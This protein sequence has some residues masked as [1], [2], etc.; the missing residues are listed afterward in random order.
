M[1]K[2]DEALRA[3]KKLELLAKAQTKDAKAQTKDAKAE[4]KD[5]K[6][7]TKDAELTGLSFDSRRRLLD[8][9]ITAQKQLLGELT[10]RDQDIKVS[11]PTLR[12]VP[13][14]LFNPF[15]T[16]MGM[17]AVQMDMDFMDNSAADADP[18]DGVIFY[19]WDPVDPTR[20]VDLDPTD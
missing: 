15:V 8:S 4:T 3:K 10:V 13:R 5:A 18:T 2:E 12:R 17:M 1:T 19:D 16:S 7:E 11:R 14:S 6:A 20:T 9:V